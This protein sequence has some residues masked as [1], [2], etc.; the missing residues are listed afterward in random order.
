MSINNCLTCKYLIA[1]DKD[2]LVLRLT[3]DT[4]TK[5]PVLCYNP[6]QLKGIE[7]E[8]WPDTASLDW[9]KADCPTYTPTTE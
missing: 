5:I 2:L 1:S 4:K 7:G 8:N 9:L 3:N 6:T